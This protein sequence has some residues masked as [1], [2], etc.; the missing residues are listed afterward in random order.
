MRLLQRW[1]LQDIGLSSFLCLFLAVG[2]VREL[3]LCLRTPLVVL[4][5]HR[6]GPR[7]RPASLL[8][9]CYWPFVL[10]AAA[11]V[12]DCIVGPAKTEDVG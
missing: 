5:E 3:A 2:K 10:G 4:R 8:F 1:L 6:E 12:D 11:D 9:S 7:T